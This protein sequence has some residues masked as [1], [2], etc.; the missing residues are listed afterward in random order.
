[1]GSTISLSEVTET[2]LAGDVTT[3]ESWLSSRVGDL[4]DAQYDVFMGYPREGQECMLDFW[5]VPKP[6]RPQL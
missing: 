6:G 5:D 2:R 4:S 3:A 1:M